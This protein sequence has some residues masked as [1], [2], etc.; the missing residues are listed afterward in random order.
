MPGRKIEPRSGYGG[1]PYMIMRFG[2]FYLTTAVFLIATIVCIYGIVARLDHTAKW[3]DIVAPGL[4]EFQLWL[5]IL[6]FV[7]TMIMGTHLKFLRSLPLTSKQLAATILCT[8]ILPVLIIGG[9]WVLFFLIKPGVVPAVSAVSILKFGLLNL[10]PACVL[11]TGIIWYNEKHFR[12]VTG[13]VLA[14]N[15][16]LFR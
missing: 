12:R 6:C 2:L 9:S 7:Q 10:A 4:L 3:S 13:I 8:S 16:S 14:W 5:F 1:F 11:T 15:V